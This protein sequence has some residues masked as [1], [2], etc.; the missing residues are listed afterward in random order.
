MKLA[1][2]GSSQELVAPCVTVTSSLSPEAFWEK[3]NNLHGT[4]ESFTQLNRRISRVLH[5]PQQRA[6]M[7]H[8]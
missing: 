4:Q 8:A 7:P 3:L 1:V 6:E 2:K 5:L